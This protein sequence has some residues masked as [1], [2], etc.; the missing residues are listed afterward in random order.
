MNTAHDT[1][2]VA[3]RP[4]RLLG[5]R[6]GGHHGVG[7]LDRGAAHVRAGTQRGHYSTQMTHRLTLIKCSFLEFSTPHSQTVVGET[8]GGELGT[9]GGGGGLPPGANTQSRPRGSAGR[10]RLPLHTTVQLDLSKPPPGFSSGRCDKI[11]SPSKAVLGLRRP[12]PLRGGRGSG[13][14]MPDTPRGPR[15]APGRPVLG[16]LT[17]KHGLRMRGEQMPASPG[18]PTCPG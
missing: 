12:P 2:A 3:L 15:Q 13:P 6:G 11:A 10:P 8:M 7:S 9:G 17:P 1:A 18:A 14:S 5:D 4:G 16:P